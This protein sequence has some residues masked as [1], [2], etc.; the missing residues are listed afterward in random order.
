VNLVQGRRCCRF[1]HLGSPPLGN[2]REAHRTRPRHNG[3]ELIRSGRSARVRRK[4]KEWRRNIPQRRFTLV[5][6]LPPYFIPTNLTHNCVFAL[7]GI[8]GWIL[9][10][11]I[12]LT[13]IFT[14]AHS[15]LGQIRKWPPTE[16]INKIRPTEQEWRGAVQQNRENIA[17]VAQ[18]KLV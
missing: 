18:S 9:R 17:V 13:E 1:S 3:N 6:E 7:R 2:R 5:W 14:P 8:T 15:R 16:G 11:I 4:K 12:L 10:L